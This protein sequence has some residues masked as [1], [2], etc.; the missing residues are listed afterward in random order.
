[1]RDARRAARGIG[2]HLPDIGAQ[3]PE[4]AAQFDHAFGVVD[5]RGDLACVANNAGVNHQPLNV[6]R[7]EARNLLSFEVREGAPKVLALVQ[8]GQPA[9]TR[10]KTFEADFFKQPALVGD[11]EAPFGVVVPAVV[12]G[13]FAPPAA[14]GVVGVGEQA[15]PNG[16]V[17]ELNVWDGIRPHVS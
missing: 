4:F 1:M 8:D 17:N 14:V 15:N 13:G 3:R 10:L 12:G 2:L 6:R 16:M 9:Q 7:I 5:G 11:G